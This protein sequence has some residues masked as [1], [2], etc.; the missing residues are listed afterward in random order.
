[1][2]RVLRSSTRKSQASKVS[3]PK[4]SDPQKPKVT[5]RGRKKIEDD[6]NEDKQHNDI[7]SIS[8]ISLNIFSYTDFKD[9]F[10]INTVCKRWNQLTNPIIHKSLKLLRINDTQSDDIDEQFETQV[11]VNAEA[12]ECIYNNSKYAK[13]VKQFTLSER[14]SL[15]LSK[16]FFETFKFITVLKLDFVEMSEDL[17]ICVIKPL[18][19]LEELILE[20]ICIENNRKKDLN[21]N[22]IQLPST[23][24]KLSIN[25]IELAGN[26]EVFVKVINSHTS[27]KEFKIEDC[28][29]P[30]FLDPFRKNYPSL[31]VFKY[32]NIFGTIDIHCSLLSIFEFNSQLH[33][34]YFALNDLS[35]ILMRHIN[36]Y[37]TNLEEF[38]LDYSSSIVN[39][40]IV[41]FELSHTTKIKRLI[42]NMDN[43]STLSLNSLLLNSPCLN[44]ISLRK[45]SD[46]EIGSFTSLNTTNLANVIELTL[47]CDH[48]SVSAFKHILL[49][50][51]QLKV[52]KVQIPR[53][54]KQCMMA[55]GSGC[56]NLKRLEIIKPNIDHPQTFERELHGVEFLS[57]E[58]AY[59]NTLSH[60]IFHNLDYYTSKPEYFEKFKMLKSVTYLNQFRELREIGQQVNLNEELWSNYKISLNNRIIRFDVELRKIN[61]Y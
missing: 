37:L 42:L 58:T 28:T 32:L 9:L 11:K 5:K 56:K 60:L 17:F 49:S 10:N 19:V 2:T 40:P 23:L 16:K 44:E 57:D 4:A 39:L 47:V 35:V 61:S 53:E 26:Y 43:I 27:L 54:W 41:T 33:T 50:C 24:T 21:L 29:E 38:Y 8:S 52:L 12:K 25:N 7:W 36:Q 14:L 46:R 15:R 45:F 34:V 22:A 1:M 6:K 59:L 3:L 55:I 48:L 13:L 51:P 18:T 30:R 20:E 31:K